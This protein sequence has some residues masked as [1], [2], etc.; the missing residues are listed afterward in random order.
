V[1]GREAADA[2]EQVVAVVVGRKQV[3][4]AVFLQFLVVFVFLAREAMGLVVL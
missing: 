3:E 1:L 4:V 2:E